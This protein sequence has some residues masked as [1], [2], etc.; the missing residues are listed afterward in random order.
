M[1][2]RVVRA[3]HVGHASLAEKLLDDVPIEAVASVE[4]HELR[5]IPLLE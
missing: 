3:I 4:R 2:A 5:M 1:K